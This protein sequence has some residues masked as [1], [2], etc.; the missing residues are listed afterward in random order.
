MK[1]Q[2]KQ[3]AP[4]AGKSTLIAA[5]T[6]APGGRLLHHRV[7]T[8]SVTMPRPSKGYSCRCRWRPRPCRRSIARASLGS[9]LPRPLRS[10]L[11]SAS[12]HLV[13]LAS[14]G[15]RAAVLQHRRQDSSDFGSVEGRVVVSA[16]D[17]GV[18]SSFR[19]S[20]VG[21]LMGWSDWWTALPNARNAK[22]IEHT[23]PTLNPPAMPR[24]AR[25]KSAR[26]GPAR[27]T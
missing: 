2:R 22:P 26:A 18:V 14:V 6:R 23:L 27:T 17:G 9:L 12:L 13:R 4:L 20:P 16:F 25:R 21:R 11:P 1:A 3:C 5:R 8:R 7:T 15:C 24:R 10:V 19:C